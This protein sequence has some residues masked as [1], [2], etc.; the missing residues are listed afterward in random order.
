MGTVDFP[1]DLRRAK[2]DA[3]YLEYLYLKER[4]KSRE[5]PVEESTLI[6]HK[7]SSWLDFWFKLVHPL[8]DLLNLIFLLHGDMRGDGW[9]STATRALAA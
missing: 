6:Y 5:D 3:A 9:F 4:A 7:N 2:L 1:G 8:E